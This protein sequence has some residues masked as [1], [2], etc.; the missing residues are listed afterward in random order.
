[1][2]RLFRRSETLEELRARM[3]AETSEFISEC[4][5]HPELAPQIPVIP[6]TSGRKFPP[7]FASAFWEAVLAEG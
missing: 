1:M 5:R 3:I 6:A 7:S 2:N 4:L